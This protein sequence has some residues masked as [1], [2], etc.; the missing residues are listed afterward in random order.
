MKSFKYIKEFERFNENIDNNIDYMTFYGDKEHKVK[1]YTL[2]SDYNGQD[3]KLRYENVMSDMYENT[4][5]EFDFIFQMKYL[6]D[7][8]IRYEVEGYYKLEDGE[9]VIQNEF[10]YADKGDIIYVPIS[11]DDEKKAI[12]EKNI[13]YFN[14]ENNFRKTT[15]EEE[16]LEE[17]EYEEYWDGSNWKI[18]EITNHPVLELDERFEGASMEQIYSTKNGQGQGHEE[19]YKIKDKNKK[20]IMFAHRPVSYWQGNKNDYFYWVNPISMFKLLKKSK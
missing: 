8:D 11:D 4:P 5:K 1:V 15:P 12:D 2:P 6:E 16:F 17:E 20:H 9:F 14:N 7:I 19:Y 18:D 3:Y 13:E 10:D